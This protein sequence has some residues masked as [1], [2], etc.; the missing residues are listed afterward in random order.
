MR[1]RTMTSKSFSEAD[2]WLIVV[3]SFRKITCCMWIAIWFSNNKH[4]ID[5]AQVRLA[6]QLLLILIYWQHNVAGLVCVAFSKNGPLT[7]TF[8]AV[9][10][11]MDFFLLNWRSID[12]MMIW[13]IVAYKLCRRYL[14]N[15]K[16]YVSVSGREKFDLCLVLHME[17]KQNNKNALTVS[18]T[19]V[20]NIR[21]NKKISCSK[22]IDAV[23]NS[24]KPSLAC[25]EIKNI[26][27]RTLSK[28]ERS[29]SNKKKQKKWKNTE[30]THYPLPRRWTMLN[31]PR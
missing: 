3:A 18:Y 4:S 25:L 19:S 7:S 13:I 27:F 17:Y 29:F 6:Y 11:I 21:W 2:L 9:I 20:V 1:A 5:T 31:S 28:F 24:L 30:L 26:T 15:R 8:K 16:K 22:W 23:L 12:Y 10:K 14:A